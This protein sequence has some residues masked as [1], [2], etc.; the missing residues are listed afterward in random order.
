MRILRPNDSYRLANCLL[1]AIEC[2]LLPARPMLEK[3]RFRH[4]RPLA[5]L[6]EWLKLGELT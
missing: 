3:R 1:S 5:Y 6:R 2:A 4:V